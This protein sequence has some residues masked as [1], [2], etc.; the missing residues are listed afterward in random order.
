MRRNAIRILHAYSNWESL[1][2]LLLLL[3]LLLVRQSVPPSLDDVHSGFD[4]VYVP[5]LSLMAQ[6]LYEHVCVYV[7]GLMTRAIALTLCS[8]LRASHQHTFHGI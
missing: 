5:S 6:T 8:M 2:L 1:L 3:W 4:D 7:S